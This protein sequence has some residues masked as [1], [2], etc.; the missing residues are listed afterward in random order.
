MSLGI[1]VIPERD[2]SMVQEGSWQ[3]LLQSK[4]AV[5]APVAPTEFTISGKN[6][7]QTNKPNTATRS[8]TGTDAAD[9]RSIA[10]HARTRGE[11][12]RRSRRSWL[13][14]AVF[15]VSDRAIQREVAYSVVS[16]LARIWG[17]SEHDCANASHHAESATQ[18]YR[19]GERRVGAFVLQRR[20]VRSTCAR[21]GFAILSWQQ[22]PDEGR[23]PFVNL[24]PE[25]HSRAAGRRHQPMV[26]PS[27][28]WRWTYFS[29]FW[30]GSAIQ[31]HIQGIRADPAE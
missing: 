20:R 10:W 5:W 11:P 22:R 1:V 2:Q 6:S 30:D 25:K 23:S 17:R 14:A 18:I 16:R 29:A 19:H 15:V 21:Y 24:L 31:R 7:A 8:Q 9:K 28:Q 3:C 27:W 12:S 26:V 4:V 13:C